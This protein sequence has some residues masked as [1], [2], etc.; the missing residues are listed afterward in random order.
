MC[1][2][3]HILFVLWPASWASLGVGGA[4]YLPGEGLHHLPRVSM[5]TNED[6]DEVEGQSQSVG[7]EFDEDEVRGLHPSKRAKLMAGVSVVPGSQVKKNEGGRGRE[8]F[9]H[10]KGIVSHENNQEQNRYHRR[11]AVQ[12]I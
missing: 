11:S 1:V 5:E 2:I 4:S 9:R 3:S 7:G 12:I 8:R 10:K 6:D